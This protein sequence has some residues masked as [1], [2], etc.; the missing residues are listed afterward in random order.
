MRRD[1]T[2]IA[3]WGLLGLLVVVGSAV[4][5]S[6]RKPPEAH[7]PATSAGEAG[8][9]ETTVGDLV[10]LSFREGKQK[11]ELRARSMRQ[12]G[13]AQRLT[14]VELRLPFVAQGRKGTATIAADSCL[15]RAQAHKAV[16]KGQVRVRT[17]DGFE[18]DTESL[19]YASEP[20]VEVRSQDPVAFRRGTSR[21]TAT[22]IYYREGSGIQLSSD[23]KLRIEDQAGA[24]T[25]I[26]SATASASRER[27][28]V[29]FEGG[30]TVRQGER[31]LRSQRLQLKLTPDL[32]AIER[33]AAVEDVDLRIG[34]GAAPPGAAPPAGPEGG[35]KRIRCR[36]L[37]LKFNEKGVLVELSAV[38]PASLELLPGPGAAQERR[39]LTASL[40]LFRFDEQGRLTSLI[41]ESKG[42]SGPPE[43]RQTV[44]VSEPVG[45]GGELRRVASRTLTAEFDPESGELA[46]ARFA[47]GVAIR[48]PGRRAW[49]GHASFDETA[50]RVVL[51]GDDP[52]LADEAEGSELHARRIEIDTRSQSVSA[53]GAVRHTISRKRMAGPLGGEEPTLLLCDQFD[54]D[55]STKKAR[56]RDGALLRSGK[57]EVRAPLIEI[58]EPGE[59]ARRLVASGGVAS[60]LH[61]RP[62]KGA[63]RPPA[64]VET[65][66]REM[67]YDERARRVVY[68]GDVELRQGDILTKSPE[69]TVLLGKDGSEIERVLAGSP[70]E[71]RQ[72]AR[73]ASGHDASY[74]PR[75]ETLVL[76]SDRAVQADRVVL[77]EVGRRIEGRAL[78]FQVGSDRIR[79]DGRDETRSEAVLERK[80]PLKP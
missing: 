22:G 14:G 11:V 21:G 72:G 4:A 17:D 62:A 35:T 36:R 10:Y 60:L 43:Q 67:V 5:W 48:E 77:E 2:R 37:N 55:P 23:V 26:E 6:L 76:L 65:R 39:L 54:Y 24:P 51:G 74:T 63:S 30:V 59:G 13:D 58:D 32:G 68:S 78:T 79:V 42:P 3:R 53:S 56:Y 69:A 34:A 7:P 16:F 52:R 28:F 45:G 70:V 27:G 44:L 73:R 47:G 15:Y 50:G 75:D 33:A 8:Q 64:A 20:R 46:R 49:A 61:P 9:A 71:V 18:L 29:W 66:S 41:T 38:N 31:E 19:R 80:E 1:R 12:E 40:L 57:D 25:E